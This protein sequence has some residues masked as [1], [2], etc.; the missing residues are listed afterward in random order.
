MK[1]QFRFWIIGESQ[2]AVDDPREYTAHL[3]RTYRKHRDRYDLQRRG[4]HRYTV[5]RRYP[6]SPVA[7]ISAIVGM[8]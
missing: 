8:P 4:L 5:Q 1:P 6:D 3:L 2:H 7:V